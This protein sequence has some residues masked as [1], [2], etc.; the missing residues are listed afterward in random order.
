MFLQS[1]IKIFY[2]DLL[3]AKSN[4]FF[5]WTSTIKSL[6]TIELDLKGYRWILHSF[7]LFECGFNYVI[8][9]QRMTFS[10]SLVI[11]LYQSSGNISPVVVLAFLLSHHLN[12]NVALIFNFNFNF[13]IHPNLMI[14]S[15]IL[16]ILFLNVFLD[17]IINIGNTLLALIMKVSYYSPQVINKK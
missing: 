2:F 15:L 11:T 16:A 13:I 12:I 17:L 6:L 7:Q 5:A 9:V 14:F 1:M 4:P 8:S 3:I 10:L